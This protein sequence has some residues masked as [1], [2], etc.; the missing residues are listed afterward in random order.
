MTLQIEDGG[1]L[2]A[3]HTVDVTPSTTF[4]IDNGGFYY[5]NFTSDEIFDGTESFGSTSTVEFQQRPAS[6]FSVLTYG[7]LI[8]NISS[9][10]GSMRFNAGATGTI[11]I[12][13]DLTIQNT[14][15]GSNEIRCATAS[16]T[17]VTL[18]IAGDFNL[19]GGRFNFYSASGGSGGMMNVGGDLLFTGGTFDND[20]S[21]NLTINLKADESS[22][23]LN[24]N[25]V[26]EAGS[27]FSDADW[28]IASGNTVT[29]LSNWEIGTGEILTVH[30]Q[31]NFSTFY[32]DGS[33]SI[34]VSSTGTLGIGASDGI[35][36]NSTAGNI[37][38]TQA[39]R[40]IDEGCTIVYNGTTA[41]ETGDGLDDIGTLTGTLQI[42]NTSATV[43]MT[44]GID[45]AFGDGFSLTV[46]ESAVFE[47]GS[48]EN[49][50]KSSGSSATIAMNGTLNILSS[51]GFSAS[52]TGGD[53]ALQGFTACTFGG[54]SVVDYNRGSAQTITNQ[55]GYGALTLSNA[56]TKTT[57]GALD[58]DGDFS[59]TG[60]VVFVAG[61]YQHN[62]AGGWSVG[63]SASFTESG[64]TI[65][66]DGT[67]THSIVNSG[68]TE[69]FDDLQFT[70][71]GTFNMGGAVRLNSGH[72]LTISDGTV[73][74]GDHELDGPSA[75]LTM[76]GGTLN[77]ESVTASDQ[78]PDF[79]G[80]LSLSSGTIELGGAG[81]QEL[82]GGET[83]NNLVFSGTGTKTLSS[84][85][86]SVASITVSES[87]TLDVE[88]RTFGGASTN[89]TMDGGH[90]LIS[91]SGVK[92]VAGG[93]YS[94][95][96]GT[97]EFSGSSSQTIRSPKTYYNIV[98]SGTN[99]SS[100]TDHYTLADGGSFT[101]NSG[102]KFTTSTRTITTSGTASV[103]INGT[104]VTSDLDGFSGLAGSSITSS[105]GTITLGSGST[106]EYAASSGTQTITDRSDYANLVFSGAST[107]SMSGT[108]ESS[109]NFTV[110]GG[111]IT[112]PTSIT[113]DGSS[114][115]NIP[116]I[117]YGTSNIVLS[118]G[119]DKQLSGATTYEWNY[120]F[121][122]W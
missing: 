37:H 113:F 30:G 104:F 22:S 10:S 1:T 14:G 109:G 41:Q 34:T 76:S 86:A 111:S 119:G 48:G 33:G 24:V 98:V 71:S 62:L 20:G 80:T 15:G 122:F 2:Q 74:S 39:N 31:L 16:S 43:T 40:N 100:S 92:P 91:G 23:S 18:D 96:G 73:N 56:G 66:F 89:L 54:N 85:T 63:S 95:T 84:T 106:I 116:A 11:D 72:T 17:G 55:F 77:L 59:V 102:S 103:T 110:S 112:L 50:I 9:S 83:Y 12:N 99:V 49:I 118:G 47:I 114:A 108:P 75:N 4:Q 38:F 61:S 70:G 27:A 88:N 82:N 101:V 21:D 35:D 60:T 7:H 3:D 94:L 13:G 90:F 93:T 51:S 69:T 120:Y 65:V 53:E 67:S 28:N 68:G 58:I 19:T 115:Q 45:L 8:M 79:G 64:S 25:G 6:I 5:H 97:I 117:D 32:T 121:Y 57:A 26:T 29:L 36:N 81:N 52:S 107:K 46:D 44:D 87:C 42:S 105:I 78:L